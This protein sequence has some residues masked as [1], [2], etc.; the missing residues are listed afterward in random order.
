[1]L[2]RNLIHGAALALT[3]LALAPA[4]LAQGS[5]DYGSVYSRFGLGERV[6][7]GGPHA[8]AM[9]GAGAVT[10]GGPLTYGIENPAL[11]ADLAL[12]GFLAAADAR[13]LEAEDGT[14][15]TA[16][17]SSGGVSALALVVPIVP[18][19]VGLSV[20]FVPWTRVNY[21]VVQE[22]SVEIPDQGMTPYRLNYEGGGGLYRLRTGL[23]VRPAGGLRLGASLDFLFGRLEYVQRTEFP[24]TPTLSEVQVGRSTNLSGLTA[25]LGAAYR[26]PA[27]ESR[28][29]HLGATVTLPATLSGSRMR[30]LGT[31][32][33]QDTLAAPSDGQASLPLG[34]RGG[35][36]FG[37]RRWTFAAE[38]SYEPWSDFES[39][40]DWGGYDP[41]NGATG[42][43]DRVRI[44]GGFQVIPAGGERMAGFFAR[45]AYRMGAYTETGVAGP[46][47][48]SV[49][50]TA[51]TG[52]L[53]LPTLFP[54]ARF[55][56]G[57]EAGVRGSTDAGLVRDRYLRGTI[58]LTFGE[59]WFIRRRIG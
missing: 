56:I 45:T 8:P 52:G 34:V 39:D 16:R 57:L 59:R 46:G 41:A 29:V 9:G 5:N 48:E 26:I 28:S 58:T 19:R 11:L 23:G 17:S 15:L 55:D 43:N 53:S 51:L 30:T 22:D 44:G 25:T 14:G 38:G 37:G 35:A 27:G 47:G 7:Y 31:S 6:D 21:R 50:T 4:A 32:L 54:G 40:L 12:T 1:M 2:T 20:S 33:D 36:A 3:L 13:G 10:L 42:L 18:E 24:D 49:S